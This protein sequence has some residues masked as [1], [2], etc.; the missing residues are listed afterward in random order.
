[1]VSNSSIECSIFLQIMFHFDIKMSRIRKEST[2]NQ[3][4]SLAF[5]VLSISCE[6]G[7]LPSLILPHYWLV[8]GLTFPV[9]HCKLSIV[10]ITPPIVLK[11]VPSLISIHFHRLFPTS[12]VCVSSF[13]LICLIILWVVSINWSSSTLEVRLMRL[14]IS[15]CMRRRHQSRLILVVI[16]QASRWRL[17]FG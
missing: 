15:S 16:L 11:L 10:F 2:L 1:M 5:V 7:A 17:C 14:R 13:A 8:Y 3:F 4:A 9:R 6:W 12:F